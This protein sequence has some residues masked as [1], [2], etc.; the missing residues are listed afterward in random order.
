GDLKRTLSG[1]ASAAIVLGAI[2]PVAFADTSS[3]LTQGN[4]LPITVNGQIIA[5]PYEMVGVDSGN[6]T[7]FFP[8][9]YF[10]EALAKLGIQATWNGVTHTWALTDANVNASSV[11]V[12][13]GVGTGNTTVTLNGT[14]IKM[15]NT[16][17]AKDPAGGP[18]AQVTTYMPIYY[19]NNILQALNINGSF[20]GQTGLKLYSAAAGLTVKVS[21]VTTGNGTAA[22]PYTNTSG[23]TATV[24]IQLA[25]ANGNP[26]V[27][28]PVS[29]TITGGSGAPTIQQNGSYV[30]VTNSNGTYTATVNTDAN[31]TATFTLGGTGVYGLT[32]A[33]TGPYASSSQTVYIALANSSA[34]ISAG[35]T[36]PTVSTTSNAT[37]GLVPVTVVLPTA[38]A[39]QPVTFY[40]AN[41]SNSAG[42]AD[43]TNNQGTVVG[44]KVTP[45][46]I[47]GTSEY[48]YESYTTYT[49]SNG[50]A[51]VYINAYNPGTV[52]VYAVQGTSSVVPTSSSLNVSVSYSLPSTSASVAGLSVSGSTPTG[53]SGN[54][55]ATNVSS[56]SGIGT[57][58]AVYVSPLS[59]TSNA[60]SDP[61]V[62]G[63]SVT[64]TLQLANGQS[65]STLYFDNNNSSSTAWS[66]SKA[67]STL[68]STAQS[69][70]A[71]VQ[72]TAT[73]SSGSYSWTV[74]GV[75][76]SGVTTVTPVFGF[77]VSGGGQTTITSGSA[78]ATVSFVSN[79]SPAYGGY[80]NP[81]T[82]NVT[83]SGQ[84]VQ[85]TVYGTDG[86][87]LANQMVP[88]VYNVPS[89]GDPLFVTAVDGTVLQQPLGSNGTNVY[90]PIYLS[91]GS[92]NPAPSYNVVSVPGVVN[93]TK[94]GPIWAETNSQGVVSLTF[95]SGYVPYWN[96]TSASV[97]Y[98]G[99]AAG[100][101]NVSVYSPQYGTTN[102][103]TNTT[104]VIYIGSTGS[105][106]TVGSITW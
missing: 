78:K 82:V 54:Y 83:Q 102:A 91:T 3:G 40:L 13:G 41:S 75:S 59:S 39:N 8:I 22:N 31:G 6:Q 28:T 46:Q 27:N 73:Y 36:S 74:N 23:T 26:A 93:W 19:V 61:V 70:G 34:V 60:S 4:P 1:I 87:P 81:Y 72:L 2:S 33:G 38:Q 90:T 69:P 94:G 105:G 101:S 77:T 86:N 89:S 9:Y 15:F 16:Q 67:A 96:S 55:S 98:S 50:Q 104:G 42:V 65:L 32:I 20:T 17:V 76:L 44:L 18:N 47:S 88:I 63:A 56:I 62:T 80:L 14:P 71:T 64:Y 11:S 53:S 48:Y 35:N 58:Q 10:D 84:T 7:G 100:G 66:V 95:A 52:V 92:L 51:T 29:L 43:F 97:Y 103:A 12:A 99:Q 57:N 79:V 25:D 45:T 106:A 5:I 49:N 30:N 21:G 68:P 37:Q 24:W 85:F